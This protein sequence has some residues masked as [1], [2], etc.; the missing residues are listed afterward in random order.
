MLRMNRKRKRQWDH[1]ELGTGERVE[2][3]TGREDGKEIRPRQSSERGDERDDVIFHE[4]SS[5]L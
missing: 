4:H 3:E 5:I 1:G 2:S